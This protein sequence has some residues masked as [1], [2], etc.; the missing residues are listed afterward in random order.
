MTRGK[1]LRQINP[2]LIVTLLRALQSNFL[3]GLG[4]SATLFFGKNSSLAFFQPFAF[5]FFVKSPVFLA[6]ILA[7]R[8]RFSLDPGYFWPHSLGD[9]IRSALSF[10]TFFVKS[11]IF[12]RKSWLNGLVFRQ[13]L[14]TFGL[15][16]W[17]TRFVRRRL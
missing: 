2:R 17:A 12:W 3:T 5:R 10:N 14:V 11:P 8:P 6:R 1:I 9:P 16:H 4:T 15:S 13:I 7:Q